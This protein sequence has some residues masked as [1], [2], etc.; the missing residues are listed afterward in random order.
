MIAAEPRIRILAP[1][2]DPADYAR[3]FR[4]DLAALQADHDAQWTDAERRERAQMPSVVEV[5]VGC[6]RKHLSDVSARTWGLALLPFL[7]GAAFRLV[8]GA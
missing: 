4:D 5:R 3:W 8:G 2:F 6:S 7:V 1:A